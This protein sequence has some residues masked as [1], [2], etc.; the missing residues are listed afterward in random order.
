MRHL[1]ITLALLVASSPALADEGHRLV[2]SAPTATYDLGFRVG[3]YGFRRASDSEWT[4]C[5]MNGFG[6]FGSRT[7]PGPLFVEVGLDAYFTKGDA[8]ATDLPVD[9]ASGLLGAA[10]GV[11]SSFT[12]WLR[13][14]VQL[15][16]GIEVTRVSVPYSFD[17]TI[18]SQKIMPTGFFGFGA[19]LRVGRGTYLGAAF[20]THVMGNFDYDPM[21][22]DT[23]NEWVASP[24]P[25]VV[26]DASPDLAAQ[27]QFY[28]RRDL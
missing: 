11:R 2:A 14:Y 1:P 4:E 18:E 3:G 15:G 24:S 27:G 25:E 26:F 17:R 19:D 20:R 23:G 21:K 7:L 8:P 16:G 10:I 12:S 13:G 9:R 28:L 22:L 6:V 5:Q